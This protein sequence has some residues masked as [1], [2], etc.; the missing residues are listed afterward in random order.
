M[1]RGLSKPGQGMR[2][3]PRNENA[4]SISLTRRCICS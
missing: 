3:I 1:E 4:K 2:M